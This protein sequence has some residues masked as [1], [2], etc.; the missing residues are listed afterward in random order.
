MSSLNLTIVESDGLFTFS[1]IMRISDG[2]LVQSVQQIVDGSPNSIELL[3]STSE[4]IN[5]YSTFTDPHDSSFIYKVYNDPV[6]YVSFDNA[7][8][9]KLW[10]SPD[11]SG[12]TLTSLGGDIDNIIKC[13]YGLSHSGYFYN[14]TGDMVS[15]SV[16]IN[17]INRDSGG[18][19]AFSAILNHTLNPPVEDPK[20][21]SGPPVE[22]PKEPGDPPVEDPKLIVSP[23]KDVF[24][25]IILF[26]K[27]AVYWFRDKSS[28]FW[29]HDKLVVYRF[30]RFLRY[31]FQIEDPPLPLPTP[32]PPQALPPLPTP[33]SVFQIEDPPLPL[34]TPA[35]VF[36]IED[37][38]LPLPTPASVFQIKDPPLPLVPP[39]SDDT[40]TY[41]L[42]IDSMINGQL[43]PFATTLTVD[44][45]NIIT[46]I[47]EITLS[48]VSLELCK[49]LLLG[50]SNI[51]Y[52][53]SQG[54][55]SGLT[56]TDPLDSSKVYKIY[57]T[58]TNGHIHY[59]N[60]YNS[61]TNTCDMVGTLI[62]TMGASIDAL[63]IQTLGYTPITLLYLLQSDTNGRLVVTVIDA[64][65]GRSFSWSAT[66]EAT[67][68]NVSCFSKDT[69][70]MT[71]NGRVYIQNLKV[72]TMVQTITS[73]YKKVVSIG[74]RVANA[75]FFKMYEYYDCGLKVTGK[76]SI[77]VDELTEEQ[78]EQIP[79]IVGKVKQTE[80]KWLLPSCLDENSV[81][82]S[83]YDD[84][85]LYHVVLENDDDDSNY[86][87]LAN[88]KKWVESCSKNDFI[89]FSQMEEINI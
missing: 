51:L 12:I 7:F 4:G 15:N 63:T 8:N 10:I 5:T 57:V 76:H 78:L 14:I 17:I 37:P 38:P 77:L 68:L 25:G 81:K 33:A 66:V 84:V 45:S 40:I 64:D 11:Y 47:T 82:L 30:R 79:L 18:I 13:K 19:N 65:T 1:G 44:P 87:I 41:V 31:V 46:D 69:D 6:E 58:N 34:P 67:L 56:Y 86:G 61:V 35:S 21:P 55:D 29:F 32:P 9:S 60:V 70:I 73:G 89:Q 83:L 22:D 88:G 23:V 36:Q 85:D 59:D 54:T 16:I 72:G 74:H 53:T 39:V 24:A 49:N 42:K 75:K 62:T 3:L 71:Q 28:V 52:D 80:G 20:E 48:D 2:N 27:L 26:V 43:Y 50:N